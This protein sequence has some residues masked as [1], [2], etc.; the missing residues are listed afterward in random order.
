MYYDMIDAL[1]ALCLSVC[2][3][4]PHYDN[5]QSMDKEATDETDIL[6]VYCLSQ[7]HLKVDNYPEEIPELPCYDEDNENGDEDE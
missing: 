6:L 1:E 2:R 3:K 4:C 7:L 5:C